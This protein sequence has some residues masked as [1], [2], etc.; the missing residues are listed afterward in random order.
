M[1]ERNVNARRGPLLLLLAVASLP[2]VAGCKWK[3]KKGPP[4]SASASAAAPVLT[5]VPVDTPAALAP[6]VATPAAPPDP[7]TAADHALVD[8]TT[9][10]VRNLDALVKKG[11]L[12]DPA[13]PG[14]GDVTARCTT[15]EE[16]SPKLAAL[17]DADGALKKLVAETRR[18][19]SFEV[20]ILDANHTLRQLNVATSQASQRLVCGLARKDFDKARKEK[21]ND[22]R[23]FELGQKLGAAC[24]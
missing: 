9:T 1:F 11:V 21:P 20:P 3:K 4:T 2:A 24:K 10:G 18:L 16:A 6:P 14:E 8:Q 13:Q 23:V 22:R 12:T 15:L 19:C 5:A 7:L 17:P